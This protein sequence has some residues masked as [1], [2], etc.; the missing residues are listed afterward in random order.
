MAAKPIIIII[1]QTFAYGTRRICTLRIAAGSVGTGFMSL[2][3]TT[4]SPDFTNSRALS[5]LGGQ[6]VVRGEVVGV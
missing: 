3:S 4:K 2:T 1:G 5:N 6:V